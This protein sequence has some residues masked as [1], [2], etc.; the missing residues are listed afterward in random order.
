M[1]QFFRQLFRRSSSGANGQYQPFKDYPLPQHT[2]DQ[3]REMASQS[4]T[5]SAQPSVQSVNPASVQSLP[6]TC[7][8][9]APAA[10][11]SVQPMNLAGS[12][13]TSAVSPVPVQ[14]SSNL[15]VTSQS[16]QPL[17]TA[18]PAI[19]SVVLTVSSDSA[20]S[21]Q[22]VSLRQSSVPKQETTPSQS[23]QGQYVPKQMIADKPVKSK[24]GTKKSV[25]NTNS[26][27][28]KGT[29]RTLILENGRPSYSSG[30]RPTPPSKE[31]L[32]KLERRRAR[33]K[34]EAEAEAKRQ[35]KRKLIK[36]K[37]AEQSQLWQ[38]E[39]DLYDEEYELQSKGRR[40]EEH[41]QM[42]GDV[43]SQLGGVLEGLAYAYRFSGEPAGNRHSFFQERDS[44]N[45][46]LEEA[47]EAVLARKRQVIE[48]QG[49]VYDQR[50]KLT[51]EIDDLEEEIRKIP[52]VL[53]CI[54]SSHRLRQ[55]V[56][57]P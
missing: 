14:L 17:R 15:D 39:Q 1:F 46:L 12:P 44:A 2:P 20:Q 50:Q 3:F 52:R 45:Y 49:L 23:E 10:P 19:E 13:V 37:E 25:P 55:P 30:V 27:W 32:E 47:K 43:F 51:I 57:R 36:A 7:S 40:L 22:S 53:I 48:E 28:Q 9:A 8:T 31:D 38:Q 6:P 29:S 21:V 34:K 33:I 26:D 5:G 4:L 41:E 35:E 24:Q 16:A 56:L 18:E 11:Q 42:A 54:W